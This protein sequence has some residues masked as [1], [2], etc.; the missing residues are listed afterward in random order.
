MEEKVDTQELEIAETTFIRDIENR[1]FQAII[2]QVLTKIK[3]ITL[4][5][6]N[7]IDAILNRGNVERIKGIFVEQDAKSPTVKVKVEVNVHYGISIPAKAKEIQQSISDEINNLTGLHVSSVHVIFKNV[8][9]DEPK[10]AETQVQEL[11]RSEFGMDEE[12][13][14]K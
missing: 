11:N 14:E 6:G 5:E 12:S 1:V 3:N 8:Y 4:L 2:L 10:P 9:L 13:D 7:L